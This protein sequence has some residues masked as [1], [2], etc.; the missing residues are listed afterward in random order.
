MAS[1]RQDKPCVKC[2][3]GVATCTGCDKR[4]CL[5][6]FTEHR[7]QL[8]KQMDEVV[9]EHNQLR[10]ALSQQGNTS[11]LLSRIDAWGQESI[12]KIKDTVNQARTDLQAFLD[13]TKHR[14]IDSLGK[15]TDQLKSNQESN[16]YT[17]KEIDGWMKQLEQ[18]RQILEKPMNIDIVDDKDTR[19]SIR[20]IKVIE[21]S[22]GEELLM[23]NETVVSSRS[24]I[25][26]ISTGK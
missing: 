6:H 1:A 3:N 7:Q 5:P 18:L 26:V 15:M 24:P 19:L 20:M 11:H 22:N 17:E 10:D 23:P 9:Q 12:Q 14:L 16:M 8:D 2:Q 21:K 4:F 13:R 25:D